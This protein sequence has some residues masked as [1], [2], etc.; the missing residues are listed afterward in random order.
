MSRIWLAIAFLFS[1]PC[2]RAA[3]AP[4]PADQPPS[5][6]PYEIVRNDVDLEVAP[7]GHTWEMDETHT[8]PL[9]LVGLQALTQTTLSYTEGYQRLQILAYTLKKDGRRIDIPDSDILKGTGETS[10][11]G[12]SDV[13]TM[14]VVFPNLEV[15]DEAVLITR[16]EQV[17]PW[18]PGVFASTIVYPRDTVV[19]EA[20]LALTTRGDDSKFH[21]TAS[22]VNGEQPLSAGG[23]TRHVWHY[24][25]D[26]VQTPEP[27]ATDD[28]QDQPRVE[29]TTLSDY[30]SV[31]GY[32]AGLFADKAEVTPDISSLAGKLT[33]GISDRRAQARALY[34]WVS[35]NIRYVD[36][37][38]GAGGFIPHAAADVLKNGY[39]DCKDHVMLLK[40]LLA[41]KGIKSASVL[42]R[43]GASQFRL[44][45]APSPF[46]F[47][48]LINYIPEFDLFVDSTARY[49]AFDALPATDAGKPVVVVEEGRTAVTPPDT[50]ASTSISVESRITVNADGSADGNADVETVGSNAILYRAI[51]AAIQ[52]DRE[53][54]FF[55]A[56]LGADST[57]KLGRGD[58]GVLTRDYAFSAHYHVG[59]AANIAGPGAISVLSLGF[60]PISFP[61]LIGTN[62]PV[63]RTR[64]YVCAAGLYR[65]TSTITLPGHASISTLPPSQVITA[66]GI[67]LAVTYEKVSPQTVRAQTELRMDPAGPVC[68]ASGYD[69]IRPQ[70]SRMIGALLAQVIYQ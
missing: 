47:D 15:G 41:A 60:H 50:A 13:R 14:T 35:T 9:N 38:L 70:L 2:A 61:S 26:T 20:T 52:P 58:T 37:V 54:D 45:D 5:G 63:R 65:D 33:A 64:D 32:F 4:P 10:A 44:P 7:D 56:L 28:I 57:G 69:Q 1:M 12:F 68:P 55:R 31:A 62:L 49:A 43:A 53:N 25:N 6:Q 23:K 17:K 24:H 22:G 40:A 8:R 66:Q 34:D 19:R 51:M 48:H 21:I 46:L 39:G 36:I 29:V 16:I 67:R 3:E 30:K 18:F 11:P 59:H 27:G 42:I